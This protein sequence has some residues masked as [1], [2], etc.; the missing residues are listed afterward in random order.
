[1]LAFPLGALLCCPSRL[2]KHSQI[3]DDPSIPVFGRRAVSLEFGGIVEDHAIMSIA[4]RRH[5]H[6]VVIPHEIA[7]ERQ[8][9][10]TNDHMDTPNLA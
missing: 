1:M 3:V 7:Q 2:P 6:P 4:V 5:P 9:E 8:G 10:D